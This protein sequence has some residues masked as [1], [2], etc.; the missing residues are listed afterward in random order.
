MGAG[1]ANKTGMAVTLASTKCVEYNSTM[2]VYMYVCMYG[3][4]CDA[5]LP[6]TK[7]LHHSF[8][9]SIQRRGGLS[10]GVAGYLGPLL[11][12][13]RGCDRRMLLSRSALLQQ[14]VSSRMFVTHCFIRSA[15]T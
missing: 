4:V 15:C 5:D 3:A 11:A 1:D 13:T 12:A 8:T 10:L 6:M 9:L 2:C 14:E 7:A